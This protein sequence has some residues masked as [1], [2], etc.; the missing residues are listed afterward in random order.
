MEAKLIKRERLYADL[1]PWSSPDYGLDEHWVRTY[2]YEQ[3][4][5]TGRSVTIELHI[6][7]HNKR[8]SVFT[9]EPVLPPGWIVK[10]KA[11]DCITIPAHTCG[12]V[13][14]EYFSS[15]AIICFSITIPNDAQLKQYIIPFKIVFDDF[16]YGWFKHAIVNVDDMTV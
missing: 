12:F 9:A 14:Q 7:N 2:P 1:F 3:T 4:T 5:K 15:D 8:Q 16:Y 6:T 11:S 13:G 10:N